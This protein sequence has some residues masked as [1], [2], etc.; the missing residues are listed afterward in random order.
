[1]SGEVVAVYCAAEHGA[2]V[3]SQ[4]VAVLEAG[5][6]IVGDRYWGQDPDA[7]ITL[8]DADVI[9]RINAQLGWSLTADRTRRNVGSFLEYIPSRMM[10]QAYS[11]HRSLKIPPG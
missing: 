1:M 5:H 3:V 8:V 11:S 9:D 7:Q 2:E 10:T 4:P 6:G